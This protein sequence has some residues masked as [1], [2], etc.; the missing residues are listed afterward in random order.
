MGKDGK[1]VYDQEFFLSLAR[2]GRDAWNKWRDDNPEVRVTFE[3][4]SFHAP[5][6]ATINFSGFTFGEA[7]N[8]FRCRFESVKQ[9]P[10]I[11]ELVPAP[12][13]FMPGMA[14]FTKATFGDNANFHEAILGHEADFTGAI[15]GDGAD[16][17][18]ATFGYKANLS[19]AT[20][21]KHA[22]LF[23]AYFGGSADL[24]FAHFGDSASLYGAT[25]EGGA[26]LARH[27]G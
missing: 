22:K 9:P 26:G 16:L 6:N 3:R 27:S 12:G 18:K 8:F 1:P 23:G 13:T 5:E 19:G 25:F 21:G 17:G 10:A 4:V 20:F 15:F 14:K 7:A 11:G 2:R 24:S